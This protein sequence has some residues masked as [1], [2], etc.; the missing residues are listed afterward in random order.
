M[1]PPPD[2]IT[3]SELAAWRAEGR[4][5]ALVDVREPWELEICR[6]DGAQSIPLQQIPTRRNEIAPDRPVVV[7]CHHGGRSAQAVAFLR[8]AGFA[9]AIN[10]EGG[11]HAWAHEVDTSMGTY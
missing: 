3:V 11:I 6:L 7:F 5:F 9:Q 1:A 2:S 8:R 4:D 10:L